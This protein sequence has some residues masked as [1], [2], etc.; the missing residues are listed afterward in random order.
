MT[1]LTADI[2]RLRT[3]SI[4]AAMQRGATPKV[5]TAPDAWLLTGVCLPVSANWRQTECRNYPAQETGVHPTSLAIVVCT[6]YAK[7]ATVSGI[8]L[9]I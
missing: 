8:D 5:G 7:P 6:S 1:K 2:S 9:T 3:V 4:R